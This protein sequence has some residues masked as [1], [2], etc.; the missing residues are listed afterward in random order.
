[1]TD[2]HDTVISEALT[3]IDSALSRMMTRELV[4]S[5]EVTDVLLDVRSLLTLPSEAA[6][7]ATADN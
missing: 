7:V 2:Q 6:A 3:V 4:T 1:M 5:G